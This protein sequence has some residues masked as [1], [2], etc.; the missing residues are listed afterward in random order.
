M[1][2]LKKL[3]E[4][5]FHPDII[6][7]IMMGFLSLVFIGISLVTSLLGEFRD[8]VGNVR[9]FIFALGAMSLAYFIYLVVYWAKKYQK[10]GPELNLE[11]KNKKLK[12][13]LTDLELRSRIFAISA[14]ALSVGLAVY[15]FIF[16]ALN[17]VAWNAIM[18]AYFT[19]L[20]LIY[21][22]IIFRIYSKVDSYKLDVVT[23][24]ITGAGIALFA[25]LLLWG[26][27]EIMQGKYRGNYGDYLVVFI[28][29]YALIK[30]IM[31]FGNIKITSSKKD[32]T[33]KGFRVVCFIDSLVSMLIM[34]LAIYITWAQELNPSYESHGLFC[35]IISGICLILGTVIVMKCVVILQQMKMNKNIK[36][37]HKNTDETFI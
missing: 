9:Y 30:I 27:I 34:Q 33:L 15:S 17:E 2:Y 36:D 35:A 18:G 1:S 37:L 29:I 4:K 19:A 23:Y 32:Y 21:G 28:G 3:G 7:G 20:S 13:F 6:Q 26:E 24:L 8:S 14:F 12:R 10:V 22:H 31:A 16:A 5:I 25:I 11:L